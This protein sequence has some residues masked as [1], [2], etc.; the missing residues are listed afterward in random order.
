MVL[1]NLKRDMAENTLTLAGRTD[2]GE[3]AGTA[4]AAASINVVSSSDDEIQD[5]YKSFLAIRRE[6]PVCCKV[7]LTEDLVFTPCSHF[8]CQECYEN[9]M[10]YSSVRCHSCKKSLPLSIKYKKCGETLKYIFLPT[11]FRSGDFIGYEKF[12]QSPKNKNRGDVR[13]YVCYS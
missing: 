11:E 6:C 10:T 12:Y 9:M 13:Q 5:V 4:V 7:F 2:K 1:R 8:F 3:S